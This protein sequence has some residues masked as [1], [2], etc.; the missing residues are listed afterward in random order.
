MKKN[1]L[2]V[3]EKSIKILRMWHIEDKLLLRYSKKEKR[4]PDK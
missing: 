1:M 3:P 4:V 2:S